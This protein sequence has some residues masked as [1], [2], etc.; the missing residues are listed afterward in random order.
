[1]TNQ[2]LPVWAHDIPLLDPETRAMSERAVS[3]GL[4]RQYEEKRMEAE[5]WAKI[6]GE[7]K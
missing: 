7:K 1:M 6:L 5:R 3:I 2:R 4:A